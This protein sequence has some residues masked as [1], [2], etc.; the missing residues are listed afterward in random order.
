[1]NAK[2]LIGA[3]IMTVLQVL[4]APVITINSI[5]PN[6]MLAFVIACA[7]A[8]PD[9]NHLVFAFIMGL[10]YDLI[11]GGPVGGMAFACVVVSFIVSL[12]LSKIPVNNLGISIVAIIVAILVV[13]FIYGL[14]QIGLYVDVTFLDILTYRVLPCTMYDIILGIIMFPIMVK[15]SMPRLNADF[16]D[17]GR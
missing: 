2:L 8:T 7:V 3:L 17:N 13:E 5:V 1:M 11:S 10:L 16:I 9:E 4:F 12:V 15:I 14:F 6:F